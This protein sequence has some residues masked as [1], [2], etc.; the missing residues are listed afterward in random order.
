MGTLGTAEGSFT[1][2][3]SERER[4]LLSLIF[5]AVQCEH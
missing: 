1:E 2:S 4:E 5:V 3:K